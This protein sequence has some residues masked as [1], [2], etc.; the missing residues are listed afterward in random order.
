M[1]S[2]HDIVV[3]THFRNLTD[4]RRERR[5]QH[6]LI[7]ILVIA[8]CAVVG[9]ANS[10]I[11]IATF[12]RCKQAWFQRFLKLPHGIPSHDTFGRVMARLNPE[13]FARCF[14]EWVQA[15]NIATQG[16][17]IAVD[18]KTL[19]GS[20]DAAHDQ[21]PLH[22][23][24]AWATDNQLL[25]GQ[26]AVDDKS[27]EITAIPRLLKLLELTG[28]VVTIDAMGCQTQIAADIRAH[29][30]DYVLAVKDNQPTLHA[31]VR[32]AFE[33]YAEADFPA[34]EVQQQRTVTPGRRDIRTCYVAPVP[35]TVVDRGE[36]KDVQ[37]I[38]LVIRERADTDEVELRFFISSLPPQVR[39]F[40]HAIRAHWGIENRLHWSLDVTFAE[41]R[42]RIR[43]GNAP[44]IAAYLR[45]FALSLIKQ[46]TS[47]HKTGLLTKRNAA[48]WDNDVL[49]QL[50][51]NSAA[52]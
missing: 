14:A 34:A 40:A 28:A 21:N 38:G 15:L 2:V 44:E 23:V 13:E 37:S 45:R 18:G 25:L 12:G 24:E 1:Q 39:Q 51:T 30:A 29:G 3:F 33:T 5:R 52:I 6:L 27:N 4:P 48:G 11:Q 46:D 10:W 17:V 42:S 35:Q 7:D 41:D 36:W 20:R 26:V 50:I 9:G 8:V 22:V 43:Q 19:R 16:Q 31:E 32:T 47:V 49:W